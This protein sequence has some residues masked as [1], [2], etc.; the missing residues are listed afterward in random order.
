MLASLNARK[1]LK[2]KSGGSGAIHMSSMTTI[3]F[4]N[5]DKSSRSGGT[6]RAVNDI[7]RKDKDKM[8]SL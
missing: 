3:H 6:T 7:N 4:N 8:V 2:E 5:I 1:D